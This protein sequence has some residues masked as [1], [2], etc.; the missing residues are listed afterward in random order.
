MDSSLVGFVRILRSHD[1]RVSPAETLDALAAAEALGYGDRGR[2]RIGLA[3]ALAKSRRE[4]EIFGVL[5]DRYFDHSAGDFATAGTLADDDGPD[6]STPPAATEA[7]GDGQGGGGS[8]E[9]GDP[10]LDRAAAGSERVRDLLAS[11][12]MQALLGGQRG[13]LSAR[14]RRAGRDAGIADIRLFTQKGQYTRRILAAMGEDQL[15][16]AII[17]L[18][19]RG[20]PA[21]DRLRSYRDLLREQ[22]RDYVDAQYLLHAEGHNRQFMDDVL[23]KTRLSNIEQHYT[24]RVREL[25]QRMARKLASRHSPRPR[26]RRRGR[27]DMARTLRA[28]IPHDGVLMQTHWRQR[29]RDRAQVLALCDVSGSVAAYAKLLLIFLYSLQDV[30]PRMRSFAFSSHLGEVSGLFEEEPIERAVELVNWRYGGATDYGASL[31]DFSRLALNDINRHTSVIILGDARNNRGD[32]ELPIMQSIYQRS[33]QVI[34]LNPESR[35]AW[36]TG[37]SEMHRYLST[38]HLAAECHN[39]RQL[40]KVVDQL[41]R[42]VH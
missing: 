12:L 6:S 8:G 17:D 20:D 25:V 15:R 18:E 38:C 32:P 23:A 5:F 29:R 10:V 28:G 41:L 27:L 7:A 34:W 37:D 3:A 4:E 42:S 30:L 14:L 19:R 26:P 21:L 33:K 1:L 11:P 22:V 36:G 9:S 24:A 31:R 39:L 40:E 35:R 16:G 13:E 2:L